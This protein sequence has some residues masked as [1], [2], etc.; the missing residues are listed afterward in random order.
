MESEKCVGNH[1]VPFGSLGGRAS[2][3][4]WGEILFDSGWFESSS[5]TT[6]PKYEP[7]D[8]N[9]TASRGIVGSRI[10]YCFIKYTHAGAHIAVEMQKSS[11]LVV[12]KHVYAREKERARERERE[13]ESE[14]E[15]CVYVCV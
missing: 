11:K 12:L 14:R 1:V 10:F 4:F 3:P 6:W 15:R 9:E 8:K 2:S 13:R 5:R 7:R